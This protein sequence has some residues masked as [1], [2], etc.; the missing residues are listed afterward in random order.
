MGELTGN[1]RIYFV[2][3][4]SLA[5][6]FFAIAFRKSENPTARF[7]VRISTVTFI[8]IVVVFGILRPFVLGTAIIPSDSMSPT[9]HEGDQVI[10]NKIIYKYTEPAYGDVIVFKAPPRISSGKEGDDYIK[11]I[12]GLPGDLLEIKDHTLYRNGEPVDEPFIKEP[13]KDAMWPRIVPN[14]KIFVMGD[15]RNNSFDSRDWGPFDQNLIIGRVKM[16]IWPPNRRE[17]I[18]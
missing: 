12:V 6:L 4:L 5:F 17:L 13:M 8:A 11:R 14:G 1:I 18:Q 7:L 3:A 15:N 9:L 2:I 10:V 16:I